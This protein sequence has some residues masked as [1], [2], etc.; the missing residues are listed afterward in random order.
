MRSLPFPKALY[1][2]ALLIF[3]AAELFIVAQ[4][5]GAQLQDRS[6][7]MSDQSPSHTSTIYKLSFTPQAN[8]QEI[9]VDFCSNSPLYFDVCSAVGGTDVPDTSGVSGS[10]ITSVSDGSTDHTIKIVGQT[11]VAGTP[12]SIEIQGLVN[13]SITDPFYA[14]V[15]T[16]PNGGAAAYVP[17]N[18]N[19][20][21][22][23][24]GAYTDFGGLALTTSKT[25]DLSAYVAP[26]LK[27]CVGVTITSYNCASA[28]GSL[29]ELGDFSSS[30]TSSATSQ[31]VVASNA[32]SGYTVQMTGN[33][34]T[35]GNNIIA[36]MKNVDIS[37]VGKAQFGLNLVHNTVPSVGQNVSGPGI[38][39]AEAPYNQTNLFKFVSGDQIATA[40][41]GA[42]NNKYTVSYIVNIPSSQAI[43]IYVATLT[44]VTTANF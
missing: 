12:Y 16:Y 24:D 4:V 30:H 21:P 26:Y 7:Q 42:D 8:A 5:S 10:G 22:P 44:Y 40:A 28:T 20:T 3:V 15:F 19:V 11:M 14:R 33:T 23:T 6:I 35:S 18:S 25:I 41:S 34:M 31:M 13:P 37:R 2:L 43:G 38:G 29:L 36:A 32:G 17:V 1:G 9:I 27:M 39:A